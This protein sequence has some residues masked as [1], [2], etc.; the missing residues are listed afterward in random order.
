MPV[1]SMV[2]FALLAGCLFHLIANPVLDQ[3]GLG[4]IAE[5]FESGTLGLSGGVICGSVTDLLCLAFGSFTALGGMNARN[6]RWNPLCLAFLMMIPWALLTPQSV[7]TQ[8][9]D[10]AV[11][12]IALICVIWDWIWTW[13]WMRN[14]DA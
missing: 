7:A 3:A 6:G 11:S 2:A 12:V 13:R 5:R 1:F 8:G 4:Q 14:E 10:I 9:A